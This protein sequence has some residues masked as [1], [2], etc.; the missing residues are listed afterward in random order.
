[1]KSDDPSGAELADRLIQCIRNQ[2]K[3][4]LRIAIAFSGGVDSSV[5]AAAAH[6]L[7]LM[8]HD[9]VAE[10]I[11]AVSPSVARWQRS[12]AERIA[13]EI[14]IAHRE[15]ETEEM[16]RQ[17]YQR[18]D[19]TRCYFCKDTLYRTMQKILDEE[20]ASSLIV[21]GT[22]ADDLGDHRPGLKAGE[23]QGI[24][25]PLADLG[26]TKRQVR[27]LAKHFEL[28]NWDLPASPCLAS[29]VA[30]GVTVT[31]ERL[32]AIESAEGLLR[33][34]GL[35]DLRVR[36]HADELARIEVPVE[37]VESFARVAQEHDLVRRFRELGFRYAT[38][39]LQGLR[40]G[41]LNETFVSIDA[42]MPVRKTTPVA[43]RKNP[44]RT[45]AEQIG[46]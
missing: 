17:E 11:T 9:Y 32:A 37:A 41:S 13:G 3:D 23:Q 5:V 43:S 30:Y 44:Q 34:W 22:N 35:S 45:A 12:M 1:M 14:G 6:R 24:R 21:S 19:S 2:A 39:D 25:T 26:I 7:A 28:S 38:L 8:D 42:M 29:R 31:P 20:G 18:N 46:T 10:A 27:S 15:V 16:S 36:L 40:S 33:E 4:R